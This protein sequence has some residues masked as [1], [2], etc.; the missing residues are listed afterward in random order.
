MRHRRVF[1]MLVS[2][3][4]LALAV[5]APAPSVAAAPGR[6]LAV[7]PAAPEVSRERRVALV[8]GNSA[9]RSSPLKNPVNDARAMASALRDCG[10]EVTKLEN[11]RR[12]EMRQ[13]LR[14][15]AAHIE[16]GGVG[17]FYFAGHGM[18]VKGRNYLVPVDADIQSDDEVEDQALAADA[19]TGKM[20]AAKNRVN[21]IILDACRN[22]PFASAS[23]SG[24]QGLA[25]MDAPAGSFIAYATAPGSTAADGAGAN[26]LYTQYLL[27]AMAEPGLKLEEV[28]K[29][30]RIGV[31]QASS[32]R[33]V[34][35][36]S[37][38][39][40]GDFYFKGTAAPAPAAP[41]PAPAAPARPG[42][43]LLRRAMAAYTGQGGTRSLQDALLLFIQ[44]ADL[45]DVRQRDR[46]AGQPGP[47]VGLLPQG[48]RPGQPPG[49]ERPR[50]GLLRR[51]AG[52]RPGEGRC[53]GLRVVRQGRAAG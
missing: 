10:F 36:D 30:V 34:P 27:R 9:Y 16:H 39:M 44:A 19:V 1:S 49:P 32:D 33:Q 28:F 35:W 47:G 2:V 50:A 3:S 17:L 46:H 14:D 21:V 41:G 18:A 11:A 45:G 52:M 53:Q 13:A 37:S 26:G 43:D 48:R 8:I 7:T 15:F 22:N 4:A 40:T 6:G 31:K 24:R 5:Q 38:S 12:L 42:D 20:E 23:R 25:Q 29:R 51:S